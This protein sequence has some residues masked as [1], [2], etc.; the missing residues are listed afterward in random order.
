MKQFIS[1]TLWH[2]TRGPRNVGHGEATVFLRHMKCCEV[3]VVTKLAIQEW[4]KCSVVPA[5]TD[6]QHNLVVSINFNTDPWNLTLNLNCPWRTAF[7]ISAACKLKCFIKS[8][9]FI[10]NHWCVELNTLGGFSSCNMSLLLKAQYRGAG[11]QIKG[12]GCIF[13]TYYDS[14]TLWG[15]VTPKL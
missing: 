4:S 9:T 7:L 1:I 6:T 14:D 2:K 10:L 12:G 8:V 3:A 13:K 11:A 15:R 5:K